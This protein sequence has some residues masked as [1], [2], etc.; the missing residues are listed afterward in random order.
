MVQILKVFMSEAV[1][2]GYTKNMAFKHKKF[3]ATRTETDAVYLTEAEILHLY[4]FDLSHRPALAEARDLFVFGC[5]VGLRYSD[6][7]NVK[8]ENIVDVDGEKFIR[9][10]TKKTKDVVYIPCNPMVL[11]IFSK[12]DSRPN[13]LPKAISEQPFN[14]YIKE[15]AKLA[16]MTEKGRLLSN[17]DAELWECI[18]SHTARRSFATNYYLDGFPTIDL[19]RITGHKTERSFLHYIKISKLDAAK[20]MAEHNRRK[21]WAV[22]V[23]GIND[24]LK[25]AI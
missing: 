24:K 7:S 13:K 25:V 6:Y 12:Y 22:L 1:D 17:P 10:K 9:I 19:M 18:S 23:G 11:D 14:R 16:G 15:A 2:L 4:N 5:W 3:T 8:P 20:R 21:N